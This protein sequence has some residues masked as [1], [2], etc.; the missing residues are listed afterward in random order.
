MYLSVEP[1]IPA[2]VLGSFGSDIQLLTKPI[3]TAGGK[4][5]VYSTSSL[6][7]KVLSGHPYVVS[8]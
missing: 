3:P 5:A 7:I 1:L 6:F 8:T 4:L 2:I